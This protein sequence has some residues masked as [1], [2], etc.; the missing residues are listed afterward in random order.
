MGSIRV[1]IDRGKCMYA[2]YVQW[3]PTCVCVPSCAR[4]Q[5][6]QLS[7]SPPSKPERLDSLSRDK[8]QLIVQLEEAQEKVCARVYMHEYL[9]ERTGMLCMCV[10]MYVCAC[11]CVSIHSS[12]RVL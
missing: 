11:V 9:C 6:S 7:R 5:R 12:V 1:C 8:E 3:S 10:Y 4:P 2:T